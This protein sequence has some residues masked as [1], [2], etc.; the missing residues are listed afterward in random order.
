M[1]TYPKAI[2]IDSSFFFTVSTVFGE[3]KA[4]YRSIIGLVILDAAGPLTG[5][6]V[7]G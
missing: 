7:A 5:G 3:P 4:V 2:E 1:T 6:S